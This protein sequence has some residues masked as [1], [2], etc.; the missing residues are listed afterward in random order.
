MAVTGKDFYLALVEMNLDPVAVEFDFVNP[1]VSRR[2][3]ELE[4]GKLRWNGSR[5]LRRLGAF[6]HPRNEAGARTLDH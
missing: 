3:P 2:R 5:H 6:D 1:L 4:R